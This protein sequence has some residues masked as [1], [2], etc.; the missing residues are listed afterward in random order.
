MF[1]ENATSERNTTE[2]WDLI[3]NICDEIKDNINSAKDYVRSITERM[4]H[5]SPHVAIQAVTVSFLY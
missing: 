3:L 2:P 1:A 4:G 5:K